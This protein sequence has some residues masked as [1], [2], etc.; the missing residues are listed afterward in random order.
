MIKAN[1]QQFICKCNELKHNS[2]IWILPYPTWPTYL[3]LNSWGST[4]TITAE[5][6]TPMQEK[7][8]HHNIRECEQEKSGT[9][10]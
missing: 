4:A 2:N 8:Q 3:H 1:E 5:V 10:M 9:N 6:L 7:K